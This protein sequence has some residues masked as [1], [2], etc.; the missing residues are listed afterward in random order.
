MK[1]VIF[2]AGKIA[3]GF[4]AHLLMKSGFHITFVEAN[5]EL[6]KSL[7]EKGRYYINVMGD[8][9]A[10]E[11]ISGFDCINLENKQEIA[12]ALCGADVAFTA[13]GG[14]NL[15][16]LAEI[17]ADSYALAEK[18]LNGRQFS[19]ITC[20]NWKDPGPQLK[21]AI[22][23]DLKDDGLREAFGKNVG[24]SEAV[25]LRSAVEPTEEVL[26]ID[27]NSVSVS[28]YWELPVDKS[29]IIGPL[30]AFFGVEYLDDFAGFL[31]QKIYTFNTSNATIA[32]LGNRK[33]FKYLADA[34][35]DPEI[36]GIL[37]K[38]HGEINP[39][40]A[41]EMNVPLHR[42]VEFS[43][44]AISKYQDRSVVDF[45]ERHAR[46]PVRKLQPFDRIIGTA[47]LCE[48]HGIVPDNLA[49]TA[50][51]AIFYVTDNPQDPSAEQLKYMRQENGPAYVLKEV[52]K[53]G[54]NEPLAKLV[55]EKVEYLRSKGW[56]NE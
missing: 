2:G 21:D 10:S 48:K 29:K 33:G 50:A 1:A 13:V 26:A 25:I 49:I 6:I 55:L 27:K 20:E 46:D 43:Q 7:E 28:N 3:R 24:I 35:N 14:K 42:Q 54:E 41:R 53:I 22:L 44:K 34:A 18:R 51:A 52:C 47:R 11:W 8:P 12:D 38:V 45:T 40:I 37:K 23:S 9:E 5:E 15:I 16:S 36:V 17:I 19:I 31:Q 30:P 39:A 56:I 32:Y 4:I